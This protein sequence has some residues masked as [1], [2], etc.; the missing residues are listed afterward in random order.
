MMVIPENKSRILPIPTKRQITFHYD[1]L[2]TKYTIS[3]VGNPVAGLGKAYKCGSVYDRKEETYQ[4][5]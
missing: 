3:D 2:N 1:S 4:Y 5:T